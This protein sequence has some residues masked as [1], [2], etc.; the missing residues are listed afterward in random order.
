MELRLDGS[1]WQ[2]THLM[3]TE[4]VWRQVWKEDWD[5]QRLSVAGHW[6]RGTVPG[7]VIADALDAQLIASPYMDMQSRAAE[8]TSERDWVY[9]KQ[10]TVPLDM[11]GNTVRLRFDGVDYTGYV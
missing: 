11:Q 8:W 9:R 7:D 2:L 10:F 1:D 3:P 5:P 6:M 4:W